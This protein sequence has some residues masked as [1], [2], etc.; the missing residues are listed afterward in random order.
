MSAAPPLTIVAFALPLGLDQ[1]HPDSAHWQRAVDQEA[2]D[3]AWQYLR[4]ASVL[5]RS[6][7]PADS[8]SACHETAWGQAM[9]W[10][11]SDGLV[12]MAA[13]QAQ[14]LGLRCPPAHGW[15]FIDAVNWHIGQGQV[16][17]HVPT[18]ITP[19]ESDALLLAMQ[20]FMAQDGIELHRLQAGRWLAHGTV[21]KHLPSV[22]LDRV[23]DQRIDV[24]LQPGSMAAQS[25]A[26][27]Q[28]RRLQNEMQMLFYTHAV[29]EH[30]AVAINSVWFSGTGDL[31]LPSDTATPQVVLD[32]SL[33]Q[34]WLAQSPAVFLPAFKL[35]VNALI[36]PTLLRQEQVL[37]CHPHRSVVL[38]SPATDWPSKLRQWFRPS[39]LCEVLQ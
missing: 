11:V 37:L 35:V 12:P 14:H 26:Q 6:H 10:Q 38:Q 24:F 29:N 17:L 39:L 27:R 23:N 25:P 8:L 30:R 15:A 32:A 33:Q 36:V 16:T 1:G 18:P 20:P 28:L 9:G 2:A 7:L 21:F 22:S 13:W 3:A 34:A 19:E 5:Q 31:P 4:Q